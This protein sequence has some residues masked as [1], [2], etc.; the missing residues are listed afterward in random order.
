MSGS[1][2]RRSVRGAALSA[3]AVTA[4][5]D[6][7]VAHTLWTPVAHRLWTSCASR[8]TVR[9]AVDGGVYDGCGQSCQTLV[10]RWSD[11]APDGVATTNDTSVNHNMSVPSAG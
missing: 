5:T 4:G 1:S 6:E 8:G 3:P 2:G 10:R 7:V 11:G 9:R